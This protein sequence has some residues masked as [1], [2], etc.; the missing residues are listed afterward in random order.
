MGLEPAAVEPHRLP[1][2]RATRDRHPAPGLCDGALAS[3]DSL[4]LA[5]YNR[6]RRAFLAGLV[7]MAAGI[8]LA[9]L[10]DALGFGQRNLLH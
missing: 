7:L 9:L 2:D 4:V 5:N 8:A 10:L 3:P 6:A 1:A